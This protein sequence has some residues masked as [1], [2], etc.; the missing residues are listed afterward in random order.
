[1]FHMKHESGTGQ[2]TPARLVV[3]V[4]G[5]T[6]G[7]G[8]RG[9][10]SPGAASAEVGTRL[11]TIGS[12]VRAD[13]DRA[14]VRMRL[15]L[16]SPRGLAL[17]GLA[18]SSSV[19]AATLAGS[20]TEGDGGCQE[21]WRLGV[22]GLVRPSW[23]HLHSAFASRPRLW[24]LVGSLEVYGRTRS[25]RLRAAQGWSGGGCRLVALV[26][27]RSSVRADVGGGASRPVRRCRV[28]GRPGA[29]V[30]GIRGPGH[31]SCRATMADRRADVGQVLGCDRGL[32]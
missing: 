32:N 5:C 27:P 11:G 2:P 28:P 8:R 18:E 7:R 24:P 30:G 31:R 26:L 19:G 3:D 25:R 6:E 15:R 20:C 29:V 14:R 23:L 12:F 17:G 4:S 13:A 16:R 10:S 9:R 22:G 1:M 21:H